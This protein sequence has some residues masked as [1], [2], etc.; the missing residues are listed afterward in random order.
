M[1]KLWVVEMLNHGKWEPTV[2]C[3]LTRKEADSEWLE[4]KLDNP[5]DK[6][7]I[8]KYVP[9]LQSDILEAQK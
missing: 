1:N 9:M 5:D 4:W 3:A 7:R 8:V 2:G 6:F